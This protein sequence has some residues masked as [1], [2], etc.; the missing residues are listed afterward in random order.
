VFRYHRAYEV[1]TQN[2]KILRQLNPDVPVHGLYGGDDP[3]ENLPLELTSLLDSNWKMP[4]D[5]PYYKWKNG[6]LCIRMWFKEVGQDI[7]FEHVYFLEWDQ[8]FLTP[9]HKI[10]GPL[11][12]NTNYG[13]IFGDLKHV[14]EE[15]WYWMRE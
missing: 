1:C 9:L 13:T 3:L 8:L 4:L 15:R 6:D 12:R 14:T 11:D 2:L 7:D 5:D 10:Y